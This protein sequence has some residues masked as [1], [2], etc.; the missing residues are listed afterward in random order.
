MSKARNKSVKGLTE[1]LNFILTHFGAIGFWLRRM[2]S[3]DSSL[4]KE[5]LMA[6]EKILLS[7]ERLKHTFAINIIPITVPCN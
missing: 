2:T 4:V 7:Q 3:S 6:T 5:M 1:S